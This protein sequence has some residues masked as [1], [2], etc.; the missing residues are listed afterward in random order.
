MPNTAAIPAPHTPAW[1][2]NAISF[3]DMLDANQNDVG[4]TTVPS[5][6]DEF[7]SYASKPQTPCITT[8]SIIEYWDV[9]TYP[10]ALRGV[11]IP[12]LH[13]ECAL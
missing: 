3:L 10:D 1:Q 7:R 6:E 11:L 2:R 4:S 9:S 13:S 8:T 5:V 12:L